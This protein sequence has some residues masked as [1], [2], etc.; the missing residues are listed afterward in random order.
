VD[1]P[2]GWH[3]GPDAAGVLRGPSRRAALE[4]YRARAQLALCRQLLAHGQGDEPALARTRAGLTRSLRLAGLALEAGAEGTSP[5]GQ[6]LAVW[7]S[8]LRAA[9]GDLVGQETHDRAPSDT[10]AGGPAASWAAASDTAAPEVRLVPVRE[11]QVQEALLLSAWWLGGLAALCLA[12]LSSVLRALARWL[13]PEAL[14]L[15]GVAAAQVVG[16]T[17]AVVVLVLAGVLARLAVMGLALGRRV[18]RPAPRVSGS[19]GLRG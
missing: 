16:V 8:Q 6:S 14:L 9:A 13:W 10:W 2:P 1:V 3:L 15:A 7:R 17:V 18:A 4:L 5:D 11:E 19:T 12:T